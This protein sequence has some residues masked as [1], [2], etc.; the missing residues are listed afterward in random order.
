MFTVHLTSLI[1]HSLTH[2]ITLSTHTHTLFI[3][4]YSL[5]LFLTISLSLHLT[6]SITVSHSIFLSLSNSINLCLSFIVLSRL[7]KLFLW[8]EGIPFETMLFMVPYNKH[9]LIEWLLSFKPKFDTIHLTM[10]ESTHLQFISMKFTSNSTKMIWFCCFERLRFQTRLIEALHDSNVQS[11]IRDVWIG[12]WARVDEDLSRALIQKNPTVK[13]ENFNQE[14]STSIPTPPNP[15]NI[16]SIPEL[17][18]KYEMVFDKFKTTVI[19][20]A[21]LLAIVGLLLI[22]AIFLLFLQ[23]RALQKAHQKEKSRLFGDTNKVEL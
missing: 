2:S 9:L 15:W 4:H 23:R 21:S 6:H 10:H 7:N 19:V 5:F 14:P 22:G 3:I 20:L 12:I 16:T 17:L 13:S 8:T 1:L 11:S 18:E